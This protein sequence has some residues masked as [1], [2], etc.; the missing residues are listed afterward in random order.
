VSKESV[1]ENIMKKLLNLS[2]MMFLFILSSAQSTYAGD[3]VSPMVIEGAKTVTTEEAKKLFDDGVLFI[4]VRKDKDWNAGRV[5]D[6]VQLNIKTKLS[7]ETM[8]AEMKKTDP[9]VIYCNGEK[10]MRSS[11]ACKKAVEWGFTNLYYYRDGFP[12]WKN[13]GY[14]V[15]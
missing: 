4:D 12:A 15:E 14:P 11:K 8:L 6:A 2:A 1:E 13:A 7:E 5:S 9:A 3:G 10:C